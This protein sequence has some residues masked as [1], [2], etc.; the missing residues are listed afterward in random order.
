MSNTL[1]LRIVDCPVAN[2]YIPGRA[3]H[4]TDSGID[5]YCPEQVTVPP[6]SMGKLDFKVQA[7]LYAEADA[8]SRPYMLVPRSSIKNTPLRMA[9][10]IGIIDADY[11]GNLIAFVDNISDREYTVNAGDRLF[12]VVAPGLE[13]MAVQLVGALGETVR[14]TNGFGSTG[15]N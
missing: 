8:R 4:T 3:N 11:R 10:S 5:L 12:Q 13:P 7:A 1:C 6:R 14:G 2:R 15:A 9:N